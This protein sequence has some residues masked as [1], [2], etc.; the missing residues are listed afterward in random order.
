MFPIFEPVMVMFQPVAAGLVWL[1][2]GAL[3]G[4]V[5]VVGLVA[6]DTRRRARRR[7][8]VV[9]IRPHLPEAA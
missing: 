8:R 6:H 5:A 1:G 4:I 9:P 2:A 3:G 7:A